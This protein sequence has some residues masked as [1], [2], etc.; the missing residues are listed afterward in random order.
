MQLDADTHPFVRGWRISPKHAPS[1]R[2]HSGNIVSP[3]NR[4]LGRAFSPSIFSSSRTT[5]GHGSQPV[6]AVHV[7][8]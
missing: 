3:L 7:T 1:A 4:S 5:G 8:V 6:I 2:S